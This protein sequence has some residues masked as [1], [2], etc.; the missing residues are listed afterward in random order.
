ML[1]AGIGS[2]KYHDG[3]D[4][5]NTPHMGDT[6]I[7]KNRQD[8]ERREGGSSVTNLTKSLRHDHALNSEQAHKKL[9]QKKNNERFRAKQ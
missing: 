4:P 8:A 6:G 5:P 7:T 1:G 2:R 9:F 3:R